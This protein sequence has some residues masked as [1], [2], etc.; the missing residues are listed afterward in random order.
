MASLTGGRFSGSNSCRFSGLGLAR[1]V[2]FSAL[3]TAFSIVMPWE[4][5]I[6]APVLSERP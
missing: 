5:A 3:Q 2:A 1:G 4:R 6:L